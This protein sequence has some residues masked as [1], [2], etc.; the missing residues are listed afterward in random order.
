MLQMLPLLVTVAVRRSWLGG[1]VR[2]LRV[3]LN[4]DNLARSLRVVLGV[5]VVSILG[6]VVSNC[7]L[8]VWQ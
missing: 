5:D 6:Q 8:C 1:I 4:N 7:I 3:V 2:A